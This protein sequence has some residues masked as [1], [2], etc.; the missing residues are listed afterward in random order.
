M[1]ILALLIIIVFCS[2]IFLRSASEGFRYW[3]E[4]T[5]ARQEEI[6][7][8]SIWDPRV[9][10]GIKSSNGRISS[11]LSIR[12]IDVVQPIGGNSF[13]HRTFAM[14]GCFLNCFSASVR[15][16]RGR[17]EELSSIR[18]GRVCTAGGTEKVELKIAI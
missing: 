9:F 7:S 18:V 5:F 11:L 13:S 2:P 4:Y 10:H 16:P 17:D 15:G 12:A 8:T 3:Y 1:P 6:S 14:S